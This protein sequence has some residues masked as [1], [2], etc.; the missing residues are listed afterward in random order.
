MKKQGTLNPDAH[1]FQPGI[2]RT[3]NGSVDYNGAAFTQ[4]SSKAMGKE[5]ERVDE[6]GDEENSSSEHI[7]TKTSI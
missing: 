4:G 3:T 6:V 5:I 1:I 2:R 7:S